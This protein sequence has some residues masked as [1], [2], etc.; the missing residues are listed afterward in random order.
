MNTQKNRTGSRG[1]LSES[2]LDLS[3]QQ[4]QQQRQTSDHSAL[5]H[6][7]V[8]DFDGVEGQADL[9]AIRR[10]FSTLDILKQLS[11]DEEERG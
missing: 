5:W 3:R 1:E 8:G 6:D 4:Q 11:D 2:F 9:V 10:A 7:Q